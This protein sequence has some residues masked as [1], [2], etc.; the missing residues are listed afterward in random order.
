MRWP[1]HGSKLPLEPDTLT[2]QK[3][4]AA[5]RHGGYER[6]RAQR[7]AVQQRHADWQHAAEN[8]W[9]KNPALSISA[10]ARIV[11]KQFG[12]SPHTVRAVI[13]N[14]PRA[15]LPLYTRFSSANKT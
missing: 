14:S 4:R 8:L 1:Q 15:S 5:V 11:G 3:I 6:A 2:G 10:V 9:Q 7:E 13:H 12:V